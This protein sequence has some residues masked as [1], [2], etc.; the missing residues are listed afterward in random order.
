MYAMQDEIYYDPEFFEIIS[1]GTFAINGVEMTDI[2]M[3]DD[4]R[5]FCLNMLSLGGGEKWEANTTIGSFQLKVQ[6]NKGVL[7]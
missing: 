3:I 4:A 2:E 7:T 5:A 1:G 6:G